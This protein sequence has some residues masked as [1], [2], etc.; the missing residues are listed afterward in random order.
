MISVRVNSDIPGEF[1]GRQNHDWAF[2]RDPGEEQCDGSSNLS[3]R[4]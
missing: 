2:P 4:L 1:M 3:R